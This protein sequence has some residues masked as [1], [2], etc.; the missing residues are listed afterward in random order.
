MSKT[1][2]QSSI[3]RLA[4]SMTMVALATASCGDKPNASAPGNNLNLNTG[5]E[6]ELPSLTKDEVR[7]LLRSNKSNIIKTLFS[8]GNLI[9]TDSDTD[10]RADFSRLGQLDSASRNFESCASV[11]TNENTTTTGLKSMSQ[12]YALDFIAECDRSKK[13]DDKEDNIR[14]LENK[15]KYT[16]IFACDGTLSSALPTGCEGVSRQTSNTSGIFSGSIFVS[17]ESNAFIELMNKDPENAN[18]V[19]TIRREYQ[20]S[21]MHDGGKPCQIKKTGRITRLDSCTVESYRYSFNGAPSETPT[22]S[23]TV[24]VLK[25]M[26]LRDGDSR[27]SKG[28]VDITINNWKGT[29]T[30][31]GRASDK[32]LFEASSENAEI[33]EEE[34]DF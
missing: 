23:K 14:G 12:S 27:Y 8:N 33:P 2:K 22:I 34:F 28:T 6:G 13:Q 15:A 5:T 11:R 24:Y 21:S 1:L 3:L 17:S 25:G 31:Q 18:D 19:Q 10:V 26:E 9:V 4:A 20:N 7:S 29:L 30:Y 32:P 16:M